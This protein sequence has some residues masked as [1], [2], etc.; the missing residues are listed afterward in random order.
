MIVLG[1]DIH[2]ISNFTLFQESIMVEEEDNPRKESNDFI[3]HSVRY[4]DQHFGF[5]RVHKTPRQ[6]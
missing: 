1:L 5:A 3:I 2:I 6:T 4:N